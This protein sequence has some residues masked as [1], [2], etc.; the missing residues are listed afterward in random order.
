MTNPYSSRGRQ[1]PFVSGYYNPYQV[2]F[3]GAA[4]GP[5]IPPLPQLLNL[6]QR[7]RLCDITK[8]WQDVAGTVP[9]VANLDPV[10]RIDND[11]TSGVPLLQPTAAQR[12]VWDAVEGTVRFDGND[13]LFAAVPGLMTNY[14]YAMLGWWRSSTA[15]IT[16]ITNAW[17][18]GNLI[19]SAEQRYQGAIP[20][21]TKAPIAGTQFDRGAQPIVGERVSSV[22]SANTVGPVQSVLWN[23]GEQD[24][25]ANAHSN[26]PGGTNIVLGAQTT[27]GGTGWDGWIK[28]FI[29]WDVPLIPDE[30]DEVGVYD[31]AVNAVTWLP[32]VIPYIAS[33][34]DYNGATKNRISS[35]PTGV[36]DGRLGTFSCWVKM[37]DIT[38]Q[39]TLLMYSQIPGGAQGGLFR[40]ALGT[41]GMKL[42]ANLNQTAAQNGIT[43]GHQGGLSL[44]TWHHIMY[45]WDHAFP[46]DAANNLTGYFD[47]VLVVDGVGGANMAQN[48]AS[49]NDM[50]Y[51]TKGTEYTQGQR[52]SNFDGFNP[53]HLDACISNLYFNIDERIDLTVQA[54]REKF[55][56][57]AGKPVFLGATGQ[58]PSGSQPAFYSEDGELDANAGY[59]DNLPVIQGAVTD[60]ADAPS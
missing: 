49:D 6:T 30:E 19:M 9:V 22:N 15:T 23:N 43:M 34:R 8:L 1:A 17:G 3:D 42:I 60:C 4:P 18:L 29:I 56:S 53:F 51:A 35:L 7:F 50:A 48:A 2:L 33:A 11:G 26:A 31:A 39:Q 40:F 32:R 27:G 25:T 5:V 14:S 44:N 20:F 59:S 13:A 41:G 36:T 46:V 47:G 16:M 28:E 38:S 54:N 21:T 55:R 58:L 37:H 52:A 12:P 24:S 57:G 45:S 10:A